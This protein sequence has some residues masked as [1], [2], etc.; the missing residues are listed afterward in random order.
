MIRVQALSKSF[1]LDK[2]Q[3]KELRTDAREVYAVKDASFECQP[4]R[5][6][7][8]LGPN[9]AGKTTLLRILA[10]IFKPSSGTAEIG[11]EDIQQSPRAVRRKLGFLTGSTGLYE[12]LSPWEL[13]RYFAQLNEVPKATFEQRAEKLCSLLGINDFRQKQIGKLSVGMKQKVSIAR[14]LIHDPEILI[15]DEP[16]AGLDVITAENIIQ[17]IRDCRSQNKTVLFSSHIMSEVDLLADDLIVMHKG[18]ICYKD[19]MENFRAS[20]QTDSLTEEFIRIVKQS[21]IPAL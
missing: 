8:L 5:V 18:R 21:E 16:T 2:K 15:F 4:G 7:A 11:G 14:T 1:K 9:G 3:R 13:L 12:R 17:L 20:M 6:C 10:T 19:N